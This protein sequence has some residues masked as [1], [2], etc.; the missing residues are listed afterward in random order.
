MKI[1]A[2]DI[3]YLRRGIAL[4][5][6]FLSASGGIV[7][8]AMN[9]VEQAREENHQT[10]ARN[11]DIQSR[12]LRAR[13]E[14][15]AIRAWIFRYHELVARGILGKERRLD[16]VEQIKRIRATRRI[17]DVQYELSPQQPAD[18]TLLPEGATA[19]GHEFMASTMRFRMRML[20]E[21]DLLHFLSDLKKSV[22]AILL[23]RDCSVER[24]A[25]DNGKP[26]PR[27]YLTAECVV[28]WVTLRKT[29]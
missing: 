25:R 15:G 20:H 9:R 17:D 6:M 1:T 8:A 4:L 29:A 18:V 2:R 27:A 23:V 14:E 3:R 12:L 5:A 16:W 24:S 26:A 22:Q 28:D 21:E 11:I 7:I 10:V 19:G 13:A